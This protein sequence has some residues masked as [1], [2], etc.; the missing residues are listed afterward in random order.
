MKYL[1]TTWLH[2]EYGLE[3]WQPDRAEVFADGNTLGHIPTHRL[4]ILLSA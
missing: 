3:S 2:H 1:R 4:E